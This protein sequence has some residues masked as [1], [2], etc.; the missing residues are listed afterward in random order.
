MPCVTIET[1]PAD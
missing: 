1:A